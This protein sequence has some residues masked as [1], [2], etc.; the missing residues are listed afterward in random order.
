MGLWTCSRDIDHP[1]FGWWKICEKGR[2]V[3]VRE[4]ENRGKTYLIEK[5]QSV[6]RVSV[7]NADIYSIWR[8]AAGDISKSLLRVRCSVLTA[9]I[10]RDGK[11]IIWTLS[12]LITRTESR[13]P[14]S[15]T[16]SNELGWKS[17]ARTSIHWS[18]TDR[19]QGVTIDRLFNM[20]SKLTLHRWSFIL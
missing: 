7:G 1:Y 11:R 15:K 6:I 2:W 10:E 14:L 16:K 19:T 8:E 3:T 13:V 5:K 12:Q 17:I 9:L 18:N 20:T 4:R